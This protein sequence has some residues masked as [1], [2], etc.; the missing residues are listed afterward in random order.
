M[1]VIKRTDTEPPDSID[2]DIKAMIIT[3]FAS[4]KDRFDRESKRIDAVNYRVDDIDTKIEDVEKKVT[5][6]ETKIEEQGEAFNKGFANS[7]EKMDKILVSVE[8]LSKTDVDHDNK[9]HKMKLTLQV[10][11]YLV[12]GGSVGGAGLTK[13]LSLLG[14]G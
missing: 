13:L 6:I 1:K 12:L 9:L 3:E 2:P 7:S 5:S 10:V 14:Y 11:I 4:L 8:N